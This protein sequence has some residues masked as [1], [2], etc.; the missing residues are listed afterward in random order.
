MKKW[1]KKEARIITEKLLKK[2]ADDIK[3]ESDLKFDDWVELQQH[4]INE[5]N[6]PFLLKKREELVKFI[7]E[8]YKINLKIDDREITINNRH[9]LFAEYY[10]TKIAGSMSIRDLSDMDS[11][12]FRQKIGKILS[13]IPGGVADFTKLAEPTPYIF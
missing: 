12:Y 11:D 6:K 13:A 9:I 3:P 7:A 8:K 1:L 10:P 4:Q 2:H 5:Q